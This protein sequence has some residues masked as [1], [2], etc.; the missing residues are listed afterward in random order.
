METTSHDCVITMLGATPV[1]RVGVALCGRP[2]LKR[3]SGAASAVTPVPSGAFKLGRRSCRWSRRR[4]R[5]GWASRG[6]H[7][8]RYSLSIS[9]EYECQH[10]LNRLT[11]V[12][13]PSTMSVSLTTRRKWRDVVALGWEP[14]RCQ[15]PLA[16]F[17]VLSKPLPLSVTTRL[18]IQDGEE[19][20]E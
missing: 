1:L 8:G 20:T 13:V 16:T 11:I 12:T 15:V 5:S 18:T 17:S 6:L 19:Q 7:G 2:I 9:I 10:I 14:V 3:V 4:L